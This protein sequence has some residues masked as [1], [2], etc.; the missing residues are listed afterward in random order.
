MN[1]FKHGILLADIGTASGANPALKFSRFVGQNISVEVGKNEDLKFPAPF[2]IDQFGSHNVNVPVISLD[3]RIFFGQA[4]KIF[5]E[6]SISGFNHVGFSHTG[7]SGLFIFPGMFESQTG[8]AVGQPGPSYE[9]KVN[10][11]I[12]STSIP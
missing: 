9:F 2:F 5:E 4:V 8:D 6:T 11:D 12:S 7:D 3:F 1:G 10:G